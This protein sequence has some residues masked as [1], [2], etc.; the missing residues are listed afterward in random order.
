MASPPPTKEPI[1]TRPMRKRLILCCDGTWQSSVTM[2]KNIPSNVTRL[3]RSIPV[4]G[5][6]QDKDGVVWQQVVYYGAGIG[7]GEISS[8]EKSRQ[9]GF[10][11]GFVANVIEAYNFLVLNW[12][13]GDKVYCFGFSRGAY[14]AR[15][16][17]GLV[18]DIG[19]ISPRDMQDFPEL[20]ALYRTYTGDDPHGFRKSREYRNWQE[21][22]RS[23]KR[24]DPATGLKLWDK[25]PHAPVL[26]ESRIV[27]VVGVFDTVG[28]LGVPESPYYTVGALMSAVN[29]W[30]GGEK[31]G[32]HNVNLSRYIRNAFHAIAL[33]EHRKPFSPTLWHMPAPPT[34]KPS[35]SDRSLTLEDLRTK[36]KT[37]HLHRPDSQSDEDAV[38]YEKRVDDAWEDLIEFEM[39]EQWENRLEKQLPTLEQVW[40]P[41][42]H[43]NVGGGDS[44][45]LKE[46]L[47]DFEQIALIS[48]AWMIERV[49]PFI[50]FE[51]RL[52]KRSVR[53]RMALVVPVLAESTNERWKNYG[54]WFPTLWKGLDSVGIYKAE[55]R[56]LGEKTVVGW[57]EGPIVDSYT[58]AMKATGSAVR[59]PGD[60]RYAPEDKLRSKELGHTNEFIHPSIAYRKLAMKYDPEALAGFTRTWRGDKWLWSKPLVQQPK[61]HFWSKA[62]PD[63]EAIEVPEYP[64]EGKFSHFL[65]KDYTKFLLE[66]E[67][68]EE[69]K[70]IKP[71]EIRSLEDQA[72]FEIKEEKRAPDT[73]A[74]RFFEL[75]AEGEEW[76]VTTKDSE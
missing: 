25:I 9:G 42:M 2:K 54:T 23:G 72:K 6:Q 26:E 50:E 4:N 27:E 10:G 48:F 36:F 76:S 58:I 40:F 62:K 17:A 69:D 7:T 61:A 13:P 8:S 55:L 11:Y 12:S 64:A 66:L 59:T 33:D 39:R 16:V 34:F 31:P 71:K 56:S 14:T 28:A 70:F 29:A 5:V 45:I 47:G 19:I 32:F 37:L 15:A 24:K 75:T 67:M 3:A 65:T 46:R 1:P 63:I 21:G 20:F 38:K 30:W 53:D 41:G 49:K 57:A 73:E 18:N 68:D 51:P 74:T 52:R 60:Y 35:I 44:D 22:V 43:M